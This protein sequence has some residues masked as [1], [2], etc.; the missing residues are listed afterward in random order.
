ML[1]AGIM[2]N[3]FCAIHSPNENKLVG[4]D[5]GEVTLAQTK[6]HRWWRGLWLT[7]FALSIR[8]VHGERNKPYL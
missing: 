6:N 2:V 5:D 8:H 7:T 4:K 1:V 3:D